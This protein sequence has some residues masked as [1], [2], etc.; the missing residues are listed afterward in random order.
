MKITTGQPIGYPELR[1]NPSC[2][3]FPAFSELKLDGEFEHLVIKGGVASLINKSGKTRTECNITNEAVNLPD[4]TLVGELHYE[5]GKRGDLY[6]LLANAKSDLLH[7]TA[8]DIIS[9][10]GLNVKN[11]PLIGR[12]EMLLENCPTTK[13]IHISEVILLNNENDLKVVMKQAVERGFEGVVLKNIDGP[14]MEGSCSWVKIKN[15]DET[16]Y[17]IV[18]VDPTLERIEIEVKSEGDGK[19]RVKNVGVKC[20]N[21]FK[22]DINVGDI[23]SVEH[24]GILSEGGLRHPVLIRVSTNKGTILCKMIFK[25]GRNE[26]DN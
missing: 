15:K 19:T 10:N 25:G 11:L 16:D 24:Q 18:F 7:F 22:K 5:G 17:P 26:V 2:I 3:R 12:K 4:M 8:F 9:L 13:H 1:G 6:K 21:G 20:L 23:A 14:Y